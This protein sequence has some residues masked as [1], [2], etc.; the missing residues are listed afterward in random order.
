M[1]HNRNRHHHNRNDASSYQVE[2]AACPSI[3]LAPAFIPTL[4]ASTRQI[5]VFVCSP[6]SAYNMVRDAVLEPIPEML[7]ASR[8]WQM[9]SQLPLNTS[10]AIDSSMCSNTH[11]PSLCRHPY[12]TVPAT[13]AISLLPHSFGC[14]SALLKGRPSPLLRRFINKK[15]CFFGR[16]VRLG[17]KGS[18]PRY[19][20]C[21]DFSVPKSGHGWQLGSVVVRHRLGRDGFFNSVCLG[22]GIV[23]LGPSVSIVFLSDFVVRDL[24]VVSHGTKEP[25]ISQLLCMFSQGCSYSD[26]AII[27]EP[28][29]V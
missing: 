11:T 13:R 20:A 24:C 28:R 14:R 15:C 21:I 2:D 10:P 5:S 6:R 9:N 4:G 25:R 17:T 22:A 18:L 29:H 23:G 27:G 16:S 19:P 3:I 7:T 1:S 12:D 26:R 8:I